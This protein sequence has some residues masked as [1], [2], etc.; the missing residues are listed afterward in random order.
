[1]IV[2]IDF[3]TA[4]SKDYSLRKMSEVEYIL[5]PLYETIMCAIKLGDRP[6]QVH[7]GDAAVCVAL[8]RID[9]DRCAMLAHNVRFDGAIAAWRYGIVPR[10]YLDTLSMARAITHPWVGSSSLEFGG[11]VHGLPAQG[12]RGRRGDGQMVEGL[13]TG[14]AGVLRRVL[15]ARL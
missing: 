12:H 9:W 11:Q 2:T 8:N 3:E 14:R 4:Y 15:R 13:L 5:S 6:A 10:L 7:V 1:M